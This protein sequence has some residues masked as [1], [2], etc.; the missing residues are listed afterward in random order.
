MARRTKIVYTRRT[1]V[2]T[3]IDHKL[4][5]FCDKGCEWHEPEETR[6]FAGAPTWLIAVVLGLIGLKAIWFG[7]EAAQ[8]A[9]R[10]IVTAAAWLSGYV[11]SLPWD[12]RHLYFALVGT[13]LFFHIIWWGCNWI[14]LMINSIA[15]LVGEMYR[16]IRN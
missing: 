16:R 1:T 6:P 4:F 15:H 5:G 10:A 2:P 3:N 12:Q 8:F 14:L 11:L 9:A 7:G 13:W